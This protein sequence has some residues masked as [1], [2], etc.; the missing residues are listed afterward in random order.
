MIAIRL[1]VGVGSAAGL[2]A[3]RCDG[4]LFVAGT[5]SAAWPTLIEQFLA[6]DDVEAARDAVTAGIVAASFA[7]DPFAMITWADTVHVHV[8]GDI[9][10]TTDLPTLPMLSGRGS[11]TWVEHRAPRSTR[12]CRLWL[13]AD[14]A[15][16]S[17]L[18]AGVVPADGFSV[19]LEP[20]TQPAPTE[21]PQP[22]R[23]GQPNETGAPPSPPLPDLTS[24]DAG[25]RRGSSSGLEA[26]QAATGGDWMEDSLGLPPLADNASPVPVAATLASGDE[27][28][29]EITLEPLTVAV[30]APDAAA[31]DRAVPAPP[32]AS[33]NT[34]RQRTVQARRC[35]NQH[36]NAPAA[37]LCR[38]CLAPI[39]PSEPLELVPQPAL[40]SLVL[41]DGRSVPIDGNLVV[42][43]SPTAEAA[44]L[45]EP[46]TLWPLDVGTDVSRTHV[47]VRANGW[48][49]EAVDC[50]SS[51]QTVLVSALAPNAEPTLL[52]PWVPHELAAGDVLYLGGPTQLRIAR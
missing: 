51:G 27:F 48:V 47:L 7:I 11:A 33:S 1:G 22:A 20:A 46:G 24:A 21:M 18:A 16:A 10:L 39:V 5:T 43:R 41:P 2:L 49:I 40:G 15:P 37:A 13:G 26:L 52:E 14:P 8:L 31:S 9:T 45:A 44:R 25:S 19:E 35:P 4:L 23:A 3:R 38:V 17:D 6:A 12:P 50:G 28:D 30:A 32:L 42:G 34:S 29:P 36:V